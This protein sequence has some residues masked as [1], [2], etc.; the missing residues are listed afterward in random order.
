MA[1]GDDAKRAEHV[2]AAVAA[3]REAGLLA[4]S[5]DLLGRDKAMRRAAEAWEAAG[6][7]G[8]AKVARSLLPKE[9]PK[10]KSAEPEAVADAEEDPDI[11]TSARAPGR[12]RR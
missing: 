3:E 8:A 5:G 2:A 12:K 4:Q 7:E 6:D 11:D 10:D 9:E 1:E